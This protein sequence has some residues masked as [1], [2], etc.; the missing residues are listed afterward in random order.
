M[1]ENHRKRMKERFLRE[2]IAHFE[3]HN[4]LELLL[5]YA[6]PQK[7]TNEL[8]H[9][10]INRFG[11]L[12]GVFEASY[13]ELMEVDGVKEHTA[14]LIKLIPELAQRYISESA[15]VQGQF[16]PTLEQIGE[17]FKAK[18]IGATKEIVY[19]LLMDNKYK[20]IDCVKIHEGSV[21]SSAIT[22]RKLIET[23]L[24]HKAS[25]AVLAHNHP[26]GLPIPSPDDI[27]TTN[28][29]ARAFSLLGINFPA[30]ILV[31]GNKYVNI[32]K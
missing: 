23:A 12:T 16:L 22:M 14:T 15:S 11:S 9:T 29:T 28:E 1:H 6:I 2:G 17:Y 13:A 4:V 26:A 27:F 32:L 24:E 5:F 8:A 20:V 25:T 10:L 7:D 19:L 18:Y 31:A 21:N 30:H 3:P